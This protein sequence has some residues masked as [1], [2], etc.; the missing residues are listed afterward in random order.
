MQ[1]GRSEVCITQEAVIA[2]DWR[3][4]RVPRTYT[5]WVRKRRVASIELRSWISLSNLLLPIQTQVF[6]Q[7]RLYC[8]PCLLREGQQVERCSI[9]DRSAAGCDLPALRTRHRPL[10]ARTPALRASRLRVG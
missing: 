10:R 7:E 6:Y 2:F 1:G 8:G 5:P 3:P 9:W 4:L